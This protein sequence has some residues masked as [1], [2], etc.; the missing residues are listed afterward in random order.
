MPRQ[1][2]KMNVAEGE[3]VSPNAVYDY[4]IKKG[5]PHKH[6]LGMLANIKHESNFVPTSKGDGGTS[7]GL[8][9]HHNS[10]YDSLKKHVNNDLRDWR[11][12]IDYALSEGDT[13]NYLKKDFKSPEEASHWFTTK[14]ERPENADKKAVQR[15][16]YIKTFL[17][18]RGQDYNQKLHN[19]S[20]VDP[21]EAG[22]TTASLPENE[23]YN[24]LIPEEEKRKAAFKNDVAI[25]QEKEAK[26]DES[27]ARQ[28]LTDE[29]RVHIA[30]SNFINELTALTEPA[31]DSAETGD[32][33]AHMQP[34]H[35]YLGN[36]SELFQPIQQAQQQY[37]ID[38][39]RNGGY[40][41]DGGPVKPGK[42]KELS[43]YS[44]FKAFH[45]SLPQNLQD[46]N[47]EDSDYG[48]PNSYNLYGMWESVGKPKDFNEVK[49]GD[50]FPLQKDGTY[51]GFTV[52]NE[53]GEFLKPMNHETVGKELYGAKYGDDT[54]FKENRVIVNEN[55]R[56]QYVPNYVENNSGP[57]VQN[58]DYDFETINPDEEGATY[59]DGGTTGIPERYK[60]QGFTKVGEM[61]E[62]NH[63]DKKWKVLAK[64]GDNY[65]VVYGGDPKME[66]FSQ[67][68]DPVRRKAFWSR[69]G[70]ING[71]HT[72]DPFSPL[73][74][75]KVYK[76]W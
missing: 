64:K 71:P 14:W 37:S 59:R 36:E 27:E 70:G 8:F 42:T 46:T 40:F 62:S 55:G 11:G 33:D 56:Y 38:Q 73:Y 50:F 26:A 75:M 43:D 10:R 16:A 60:K 41:G 23:M 17:D 22:A 72:K 53:T 76:K 7:A 24:D 30:K 29:E 2:Y 69:M 67:H 63:P 18:N 54:Y 32:E 1:K 44:E 20:G 19:P 51:H 74:W 9:M 28:E 13:K 39:A 21:F 52:H 65:K 49:D 66:D 45:D 58:F 35:V 47:F 48:D 31:P 15:Q 25:A 3:R 68:H 34:G 5:V 57:V 61:K 12:Q 4:L 6:A